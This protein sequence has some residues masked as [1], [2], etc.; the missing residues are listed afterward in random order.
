MRIKIKAKPNAHENKVEK[1]EDGTLVVSVKE[2]PE[3][4]LANKGVMRE[5]AKHFGVSA[6]RVKIVGGFSSRTKLI[7]VI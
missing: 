6:L 2:P 5:V 3:K 7:E 1:L 4:G